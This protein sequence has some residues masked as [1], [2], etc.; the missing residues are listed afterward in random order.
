M[1]R[2]PRTDIHCVGDV[3]STTAAHLITKSAGEG[4]GMCSAYR[5]ARTDDVGSEHPAAKFPAPYCVSSDR[6]W[7]QP[8]ISCWRGKDREAAVFD[9][10]SRGREGHYRDGG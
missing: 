1:C 6:V 2:P 8:R 4:T 7:P 3:R 9:P 10:R 5:I